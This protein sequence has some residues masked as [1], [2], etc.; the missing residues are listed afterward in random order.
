MKTLALFFGLMLL[1]NILQAQK[2][3]TNLVFFG[4]S[5]CRGSGAVNNE[6]YA[7]QFYHGGAIDTS[8]FSYFNCSTGGDN[9]LKIE[10]ENRIGEKLMPS[11]PDIVVVGL[12]LS[13]EGI[14]RCQSDDERETIS[15]QFRSRLLALADSVSSLGMIP[16]IANCYPHSYYYSTEY[17]YI[18]KMN[19]I[20]NSWKYPSINL[21]GAIDNGKGQWVEGYQHDSGHPN[22]DGHYE[23]SLSIVPDLFESITLGKKIPD[24]D[25]KKS[26]TVLDNTKKAESIT[27]SVKHPLHSFTMSFRYIESTAGVIAR[28]KTSLG[29]SDVTFDGNAIVYGTIKVPA[30]GKE[31]NH[32]VVAHN[33]AAGRTLIAVNGKVSG[34]MREKLIPTGFVFGGTVEFIALKDLMLHR[35]SLS[36]DEIRDISNKLFIRSSLEI[37]SPMTT[38]ITGEELPNKAQSLTTLRIDPTV[39]H[40]LVE[41]SLY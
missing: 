25:W 3:R 39:R 1:G 5:V 10:K 27:F 37:Y 14:K 31:W 32:V 41:K 24:Y 18:K 8:K 36:E 23:M 13:N 35:A 4:S 19:W 26:Y 6:G 30:S 17:E 33:Y 34:E 7:W 22:R 2:D 16:V 21:L 12:S 11:K 9:T 29:N 38:I 40:K 15:E 20:I 28:I